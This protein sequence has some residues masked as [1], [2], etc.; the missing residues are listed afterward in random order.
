VV[1]SAETHVPPPVD[2]PLSERQQ[3]ILEFE[4]TWWQH[5]DSRDDVIRARFACSAE[6]YYQE[7][8]QLLD[9]PGAVSVDPLVVRRLRRHRD[10]RRR[11]RLDGTGSRTGEQGGLNR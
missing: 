9:H 6:D 3:A 2:A 4:A 8:N 10:R 1:V 11:A 5:D 7:L